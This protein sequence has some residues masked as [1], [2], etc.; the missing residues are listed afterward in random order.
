MNNY[1]SVEGEPPSEVRRT[2]NVISVDLICNFE[3]ILA[4]IMITSLYGCFA[5][6]I[7]GVYMFIN[8]YLLVYIRIFT[9][10]AIQNKYRHF[11]VVYIIN[12]V[13]AVLYLVI[14]SLNRDNISYYKDNNLFFFII[15]FV[16]LC[17]TVIFL[18]AKV[19][20]FKSVVIDQEY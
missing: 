12:M 20:F 14:S 3:F 10:L 9:L 4:M 17:F 1:V 8:I 18:L 15:N 11:P 19:V 13:L 2:P 6:S 7:L 5:V 16:N